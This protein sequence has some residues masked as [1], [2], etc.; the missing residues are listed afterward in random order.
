MAKWTCLRISSES[1]TSDVRST[2]RRVHSRT[3]CTNCCTRRSL[4]LKALS[5][6]PAFDSNDSYTHMPFHK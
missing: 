2:T 5:A 1:S 3:L 6:C 4:T